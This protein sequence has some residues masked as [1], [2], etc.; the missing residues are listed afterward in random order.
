MCLCAETPVGG[1]GII[2]D[3]AKADGARSEGARASGARKVVVIEEPAPAPAP[4]PA[5]RAGGP[6]PAEGLDERWVE[7]VCRVLDGGGAASLLAGLLDAAIELTG[8]DRGFLVVPDAVDPAGFTIEVA[9]GIDVASVAS[10]ERALSETLVRECL[11]SGQAV[12][13]ENAVDSQYR[14]RSIARLKLLSVLVVPVRKG[15]EVAAAMYLDMNRLRAVFTEETEARVS[16]LLERVIG[17][18]H[19]F[20]VRARLRTA[21]CRD[22][23]RV[24]GDLG[25]EDILGQDASMMRVLEAVACAAPT[26]APVLLL[27]ESGTGKERLAR[28]VHENSPRRHGPFVPVQCG[29]IPEALV[30]SELFGHEKGAFTGAGAA[31]GGRA[32]AADGGTLFLDEIGELPLAAQVTLLRLL[33]SGEAQ[34]VGRAL[35]VRLSVRVVAATHRDLKAMVAQGKFREDL[36]YRLAVLPVRI[37]PLRARGDDRVLLAQA[38]LARTG[39]ELGRPALRFDDEALQSIQSYP[40]PGNVRELANAVRRA[41]IFARGELI[42]AAELPEE[43]RA[44][45]GSAGAAPRAPRTKDELQLA[46]DDA[47]AALERAFLDHILA[48]ARGNVAEA[49]RASGMNRTFLHQLIERH[50]VDPLDF[51]RAG[52]EAGAQRA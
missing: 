4:A 9:R 37:P 16:R 19:E 23:A 3:M 29:A 25:L 52:N 11:A 48:A 5:A 36:F 14:A 49:A 10:A 38:L 27:G 8:A 6:F 50:G 42:T 22:L 2:A 7:R 43:V 26:E 34:R 24:K 39:G 35:P 31:S 46:K 47:A 33:E 44:P 20:A 1:G 45:S 51:K 12:R 21:A 15:G 28:A 17:P 13:L 40:F 32:A 18:V 30:E 41:A